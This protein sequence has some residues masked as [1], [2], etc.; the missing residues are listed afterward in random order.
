MQ[1]YAWQNGI[2]YREMITLIG[3]EDWRRMGLAACAY[4]RMGLVELDD[5]QLRTAIETAEDYAD[6]RVTKEEVKAM[7]HS[8]SQMLEESRTR[9]LRDKT[10]AAWSDHEYE[11]WWTP[12]AAIRQLEEQVRRIELVLKPG[13]VNTETLFYAGNTATTG[14][15]FEDKKRTCDLLREIFGNPFRPVTFSPEWR[16]DTAVTLARMMY[17]A[18]EFSAMPILADAL[19]D[20]GCDNDDILNHCRKANATHVRGCWVVDLVLEKS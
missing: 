17:E 9:H 13:R 5:S 1:E 10:A 18:R 2:D 7:R 20:A 6:F 16:T 8:L 4:I 11:M 14:F 15:H 3:K 19:Q 12:P